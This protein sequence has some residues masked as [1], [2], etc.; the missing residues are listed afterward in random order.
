MDELLE[1]F[2]RDIIYFEKDTVQMEK[3]VAA[4]VD[5]LLASYR[6]GLNAEQDEQLKSL[7][8]EVAHIA[9]SKS[10]WLGARYALKI[11]AEL[12]AG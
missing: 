6:I 9:E 10:F 8:Y 1:K 7:A 4:E 3:T 2:F 5:R 11:A 12:L